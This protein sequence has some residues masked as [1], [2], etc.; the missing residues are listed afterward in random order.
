ME[1]K[2]LKKDGQTDGKTMEMVDMCLDLKGLAPFKLLPFNLF[3][4]YSKVNV[5]YFH[6]QIKA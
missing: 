2:C 6:Q 5:V 4:S 1:L 3:C